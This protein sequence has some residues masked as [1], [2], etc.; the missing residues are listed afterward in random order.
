VA[1]FPALPLWTDA[2]L[3]DTMH[4]DAA[5]TGAYLLLL[6]VA[7]RRP[8][9]DLPNDD[10]QLSRFARMPL[11]QWRR[12][13]D[14][15]LAF[16]TLIDGC[17]RQK[18]LD[19]VRDDVRAKSEKATDAARTRW[20][21]QPKRNPSRREAV[22]SN[23]DMRADDANS[24]TN[25]QSAD[26]DASVGHVPGGCQ[27][28]PKP[29]PYSNN[30]SSGL[31]SINRTTEQDAARER[32][33]VL[34]NYDFM[35]TDGTVLILADEFKVLEAELPSIRDVRALV[36]HSCRS[37]LLEVEPSQR[38]QALLSWLRKKN[39]ETAQRVSLKR[40]DKSKREAT[41]ADAARRREADKALAV[42]ERLARER[43][44]RQQMEDGNAPERQPGGEFPITH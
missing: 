40:D 30:S 20:E 13:K 12:I 4:L 26:A 9:C 27:P 23:R 7:W 3:S 32:D 31:V 43:K 28:K 39:A 42:R 37:W 11:K 36:R 10:I 1:E 24:L 34:S 8:N 17:W 29:K 15:I 2:F 22:N 5:E 16:W 41:D 33:R 44:Q 19:A 21:R 6:M 38:K 18:K 14:R 25:Q 35:S